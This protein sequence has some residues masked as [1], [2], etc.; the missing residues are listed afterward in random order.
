MAGLNDVK[1]VVEV[2]S[3]VWKRCPHCD[4]LTMS[5]QDSMDLDLRINHF[6]QHG[7]RLLYLGQQT[8]NADGKPWQTT[9]VL[10][11]R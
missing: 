11:G 10:L 7:Y 5:G 9:V 6:L 1:E 2:N 3:G 4:G 8:T